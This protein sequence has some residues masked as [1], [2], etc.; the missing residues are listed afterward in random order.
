MHRRGQVHYPPVSFRVGLGTAWQRLNGRE[1]CWSKAGRAAW[2]SAA[3][4]RRV[5]HR[6]GIGS[7]LR[8]PTNGEVTSML[9][10]GPPRRHPMPSGLFKLAAAG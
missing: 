2:P 8:H 3:P 1:L 4:P 9:A 7:L 6:P 5:A 10:L